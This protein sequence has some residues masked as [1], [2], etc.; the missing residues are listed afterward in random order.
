[1][2]GRVVVALVVAVLGLGIGTGYAQRIFAAFY[3]TTPPH[4]EQLPEQLHVLPRDVLQQPA[5]EARLGH[6]LSGR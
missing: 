6:G 1:M 3:G 4:R 2:R 5:R